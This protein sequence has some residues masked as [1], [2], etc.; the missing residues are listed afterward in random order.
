MIKVYGKENCGRCETLK[1]TS[2][3]LIK[4][5][6]LL[7]MSIAYLCV[8]I[9]SFIQKKFYRFVLCSKMIEK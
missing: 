6:E 7:V 5:Y 4:I 9:N 2:Y 1:R 3:I 8:K